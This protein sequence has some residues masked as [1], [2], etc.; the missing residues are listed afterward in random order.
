MEKFSRGGERGEVGGGGEKEGGGERRR[1]KEEGG[2][3][4]SPFL[5]PL[6]FVCPSLLI[7]SLKL[8]RSDANH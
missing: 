4:S 6:K 1:I 2:G 8:K 7:S 3:V 5:P